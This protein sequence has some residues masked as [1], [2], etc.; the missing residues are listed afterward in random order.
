MTSK[1]KFQATMGDKRRNSY[2]RILF[3]ALTRFMRKSALS[4]LSEIERYYNNKARK[5]P[6][7][8]AHYAA[9][10]R[11]MSLT[12]KQMAAH[13][14]SLPFKCAQGDSPYSQPVCKLP[15]DESKRKKK[16]K[17][18]IGLKVKFS[19]SLKNTSNKAKKKHLRHQIQKDF[20]NRIKLCRERPQRLDVKPLTEMPFVKASDIRSQTKSHL[21]INDVPAIRTKVAQAQD[22]YKK[23]LT[24]C[25]EEVYKQNP[26]LFDIHKIPSQLQAVHGKIY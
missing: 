15:E 16:E 11:V 8:V 9:G 5:A 17:G 20:T 21:T 4:S 2:Q 6:H 10:A 1:E 23:R 24:K 26:H 12:E 18:K 19:N 7:V 22:K 25:N 14:A 13:L 3:N